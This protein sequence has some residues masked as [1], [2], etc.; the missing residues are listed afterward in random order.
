MVFAKHTDKQMHCGM[1]AASWGSGNAKTC[2]TSYG[3]ILITCVD[4][5]VSHISCILAEGQG[6]RMLASPFNA[7]KKHAP[8][9]CETKQQPHS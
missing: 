5:G 2:K 7:K 8:L 4:G 3:D 1:S 9:E 6:N